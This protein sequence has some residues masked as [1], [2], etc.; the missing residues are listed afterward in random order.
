MSYKNPLLPTL[1]TI[2][3]KKQISD[4]LYVL[5][6]STEDDSQNIAML[7]GQ[8][9]MLYCFGEGEVPISVSEV[10]DN[11]KTL[12]YAIQD[13][14]A[15]TN[16][17]CSMEVGDSIGVR[18]AYGNTWPLKK[19]KAKNV[20]IIS[21]GVGNA[22]LMMATNKIIQDKDNYKSINI[23]HGVNSPEQLLFRDKYEH[24]KTQSNIYLSSVESHSDDLFYTGFVTQ[25]I[26]ADNI[27]AED[28]IVMICGPEPMIEA[29]TTALHNIGIASS[30]IYITL[31]R[32]MQ[33]GIG[34]CGHC[35]CGDKFVCTD[36]PIF[37]LDEIK[38]F[39]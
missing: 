11:G 13:I 23:L 35:Q 20:V 8:F 7:P 28:T 5:D 37:S 24:F 15:V 19:A 30:D 12:E 25:H 4:N 31:E 10:K 1:M 32:N 27:P 16:A 17:I 9:N 3:A 38:D 22:P 21:G 6:I 26:T 14:G 33:C 2:V 18:G 39:I 29:C 34:L 36:G